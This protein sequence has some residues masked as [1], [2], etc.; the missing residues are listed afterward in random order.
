MN[1]TVTLDPALAALRLLVYATFADEGRPPSIA[2]AA[3]RLGRQA[4]DIRRDLRQLHDRHL[5]VLSRDGDAIRMAHPFSAAPMGFVVSAA[6]RLWWGGCAWDSFGIAAAVGTDVRIDTVCPACTAPLRLDAGPAKPPGGTLVA[7]IPLP[8]VRWWDDVVWTCTNIRAFCSAGHATGYAERTSRPEGEL[9]PVE[10]LWRLA[11]LWY[12]D[13]LRRDYAPR[14]VARSQ[15][16]LDEVGLA[17][18]FWR[19]P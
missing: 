4:D 11:V 9:V 2:E 14:A 1:E 18:E 19:L 13:R 3:R 17:G 8:A 12:G 10:Q 5:L 16:L 6:D 7:R 15:A